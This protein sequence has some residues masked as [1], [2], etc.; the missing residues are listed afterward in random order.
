[1]AQ[2][3]RTCLRC[4]TYDR[5]SNRCRLGKTNPRKKH[6]AQTVAEL[7][8]VQVICLH[9]PYRE[10]LILRMRFPDRR[11]IWNERSPL[12]SNQPIEVEILEEDE[13]TTHA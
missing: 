11:F 4:P 10:P 7:M 8:G 2:Q 1:M 13:E 5:E 6:E 12:R 9:N 3:R